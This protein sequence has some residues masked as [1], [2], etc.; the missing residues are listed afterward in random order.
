MGSPAPSAAAM[1]RS[2][3]WV[4]RMPASSIVDM[5]ERFSI[6]LTPVGSAITARG[7]MNTRLPITFITKPLSM[8]LTSS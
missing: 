3:S 1:V 8:M 6:S 4:R 7:R 5:M 2:R